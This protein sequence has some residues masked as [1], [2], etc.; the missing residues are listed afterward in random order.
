M[1][2]RFSRRDLLKTGL[3]AGT[4]ALVLAGGTEASIPGVKKAGETPAQA[5]PAAQTP[6]PADGTILPLTSTSDVYIPPKGD[7]FF[8][9][10]FDFPEPSVAFKQMLFS[11]RLYTF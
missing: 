6:V 11:F 9:F 1:K 10:S 2:E 5:D 4:S 8:K 3:A 7:S